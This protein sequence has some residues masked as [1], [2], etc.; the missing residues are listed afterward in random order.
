MNEEL[1]TRAEAARFLRLAPQTLACW[2]SEGK[3]SLPYIRFG[4]R[5]V[6]RKSDLIAFVNANVV[7]T[8]ANVVTTPAPNE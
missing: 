6:Y 3:P 4:N 8:H 7:T 5:V 2:A 1:L